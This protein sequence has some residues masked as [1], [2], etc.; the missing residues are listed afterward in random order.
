MAATTSSPGPCFNSS[1]S[2]EGDIM[3]RKRELKGLPSSF[4]SNLGYRATSSASSR[5]PSLPGVNPN[6]SRSVKSIVA[7][8]ESSPAS[9]PLSTPRGLPHAALGLT[10]PSPTRTRTF[11]GQSL[12]GIKP[13]TAG[14]PEVEEYSLTLLKYRKYFTERPLAR[15]LDDEWRTGN[16]DQLSSHAALSR[17]NEGTLL[18]GACALGS[19]SMSMESGSRQQRKM[20][21][22]T[23]SEDLAH[24]DMRASPKS[25]SP[26]ELPCDLLEQEPGAYLPNQSRDPVEARAF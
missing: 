3:S 25:G 19:D 18:S 8:I 22:G 17:G 4:S 9:T 7:W 1:P 13:V 15:C 24:P 2:E 14:L 21:T 10:P 16:Q 20:S 23:K 12:P 6:P 11:S 5:R 26:T